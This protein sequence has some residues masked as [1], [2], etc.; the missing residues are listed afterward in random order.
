MPSFEL[1]DEQSQQYKESVF[2]EGCP[3]LSIEAMS[4]FGWAKYAHASCGI[5]TF[6]ASA[7][8]PKIYEKFEL[9]PDMVAKK[10]QKVIEYYKVNTLDWRIKRCIL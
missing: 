3:V 5:D 10:A 4:T 6:G 8:A 1:F 9:V 2:V 7:P